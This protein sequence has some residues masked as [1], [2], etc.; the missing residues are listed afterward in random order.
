MGDMSEKKKLKNPRKFRNGHRKFA[1]KTIE[2]AK[3]LITEG[4]P[5]EVKRLK[6]LRTALETKYSE[7]QSLDREIVDLVDDVK[8]IDTEVSE[9][10]ELMSAIQEC[11][12][13]FESALEAQQSQGKS[14][15]FPSV[16]QPVSAD[17]AG[18]SQGHVSKVFTHAKLPKL[19]LK[20]FHGNPMHWYPFWESFES[21]VQKNPNL[22]SV[23]KFNYLKSLLT[24]TAQSSVTGLALTS[25]NYEKAVNLLKQ[26]FGNRQM[27]ISSHIEVLTK[28]PK[29]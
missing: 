16:V 6:F 25:A 27:V 2:D 20:K 10:C 12:V 19:E 4:N 24:G 8:V 7:L 17:S 18:T 9:S 28:L 21:A 11:I 22:S 26:R 1:Q 15:E 14:Q 23:D 13:E 29:V 5:I 3:G